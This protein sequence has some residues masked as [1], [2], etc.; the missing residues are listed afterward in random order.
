MRLDHFAVIGATRLTVTRNALTVG[1][2][3]LDMT[4]RTATQVAMIAIVLHG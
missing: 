3:V 1:M 2:D 4:Q